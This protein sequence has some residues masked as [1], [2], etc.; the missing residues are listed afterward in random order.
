MNMLWAFVELNWEIDLKKF[1]IHQ[2]YQTENQLSYFKKCNDHHKAWDSICN[3]YRE[4][5]SLELIWPYVE[6]QPNPTVDGYNLGLK[7]NRI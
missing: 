5:M 6:S 2:G 1:A 4:A 3:I 7:S